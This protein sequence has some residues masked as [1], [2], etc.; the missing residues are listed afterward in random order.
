MGIMLETV[1]PVLGQ[2]AEGFATLNLGI[3]SGGV[4]PATQCGNV[5]VVRALVRDD[6]G[7]SEPAAVLVIKGTQ[8]V[9]IREMRHLI[10]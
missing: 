1:E 3:V 8:I 10:G 7:V 4:H 2:C 5:P 6:E 9:V